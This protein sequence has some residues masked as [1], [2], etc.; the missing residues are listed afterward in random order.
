MFM[1]AFEMSVTGSDKFYRTV[2][3]KTYTFDGLIE[4]SNKGLQSQ[5][6]VARFDP[7]RLCIPIPNQ[8]VLGPDNEDTR[9][10][11]R[12]AIVGAFVAVRG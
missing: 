5:K 3:G 1:S 7:D 10:T 2:N 6:F 9:A 8:W 4:V 12:D 11:L